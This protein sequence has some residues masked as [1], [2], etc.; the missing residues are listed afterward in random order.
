MK[1]EEEER[2][3]GRVGVNIHCIKVRGYIHLG[4]IS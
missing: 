3:E 2:C 1:K 4:Y